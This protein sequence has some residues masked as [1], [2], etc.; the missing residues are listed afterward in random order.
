MYCARNPLSPVFLIAVVAAGT[1]WSQPATTLPAGKG[2]AEFVRVCGQC[3]GVEVVI[4]VTNSADGWAAVV[5]D[6]VSRGAQGTQD[7]FDRVTKYLAVNFGPKV[8]VNKATEKE[9]S[10]NLGLS[11]ADAQA[12]VHFR[13]TAGSFKS[14]DDLQ[15]VPH[16]DL[17]KLE[18]EK[19]RIDFSTSNQ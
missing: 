14:W 17:K 15:K 2:R 7:D 18:D 4:K 1:A 10:T 8:N 5:D 13:E 12:I 16:I 9:L 3:H 11:S 6:M 19:N